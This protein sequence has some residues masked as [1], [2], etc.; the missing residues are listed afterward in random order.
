[1]LEALQQELHLRRASLGSARISTLYFGGGTPSL[2]SEAEI[3]AL[4]DALHKN[5]K[6]SKVKECTLEANS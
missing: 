6:L 4:F 3:S 5:Y 1:M 2:L